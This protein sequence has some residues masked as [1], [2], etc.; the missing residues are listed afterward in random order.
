MIMRV[1]VIFAICWGAESVEYVLR[2]LT[3][4]NITFVHITIVDMMVLLNS[5]VNPF[6]YALLN[7]QF[8]Q[9]SR[10]VMCCTSS[11]IKPRPRAETGAEESVAS[12]TK[13]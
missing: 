1:S 4:L 9:K 11:V 13:L 10:G 3:T 2:F 6:V 12:E 5:A 7:H 8:R